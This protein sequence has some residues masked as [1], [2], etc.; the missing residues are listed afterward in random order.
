[1]PSIPLI[2]DYLVYLF[3]TEKSSP[4]HIECVKSCLA[5]TYLITGLLQV[6]DNAVLKAILSNFKIACPAAR[7]ELPKWNLVLVLNMLLKSPY[8]PI[9]ECTLT[10]LTHK[11]AF[12][13]CLAAALRSSELHALSFDRLT[14][15][16]DWSQVFLQPTLEFLAK[17][18]ISRHP[19]YQRV[20]TVS[21]LTN[22]SGSDAEERKLCPVRAL[23]MYLA[24][25]SSRRA[26]QKQKHLF[27]SVNPNRSQEITKS[28]I[29]MWLRKLII[30]AHQHASPE[31]AALAR[32]S[33]HEIRAIGASLAFQH[34]LGL[35]K[36][37]NTCTWR[38]HT[39][40]TSYY[41]RDVARL[42]HDLMSLPPCIAAQT[43]I[44]VK[45]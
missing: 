24:K 21:A 32:A 11:T 37:L 36:L 3:D 17:N 2:A 30:K 7:F 12:L 35:E 4:R 9:W 18:Q 27:I 38:S 28:A 22:L 33:P 15:S 41:L 10:D 45:K 13:L 39:T 25:T 42:S 16:R 19:D 31:E 20:F 26:K 1:M 29:S 8:E 43:M 40:F 6:S 14:H 34:S 44:N 23:R 5:Q